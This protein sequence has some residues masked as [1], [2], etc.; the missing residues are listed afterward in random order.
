MNK[1]EEYT[2]TRQYVKMHR[3]RRFYCKTTRKINNDTISIPMLAKLIGA[4]LVEYIFR[5][6]DRIILRTSDFGQIGLCLNTHNEE[7]ANMT[8][9]QWDDVYNLLSI[10]NFRI[11]LINGYS[12]EVAMTKQ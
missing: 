10:P 4:D 7:F 2:K 9:E 1:L 6:D 11:P 8:T 12:I 3:L 5:K